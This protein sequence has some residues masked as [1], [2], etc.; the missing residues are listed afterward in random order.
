MVKCA[1][2]VQLF[3]TFHTD[4]CSVWPPPNFKYHISLSPGSL[5]TATQTSSDVSY[6]LLDERVPPLPSEGTPDDE[7]GGLYR[8][9]RGL[10]SGNATLRLK[11]V[12]T[13]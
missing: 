9:D 5:R 4:C 10:N 13:K 2:S 12:D 6:E 1:R 8:A 11:I 3:S 7:Y